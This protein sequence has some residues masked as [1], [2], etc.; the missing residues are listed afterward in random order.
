[1]LMG[2]VSVC[3]MNYCICLMNRVTVQ[4]EVGVRARE[5]AINFRT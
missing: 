4:G 3:P 5:V 2:F 1:M